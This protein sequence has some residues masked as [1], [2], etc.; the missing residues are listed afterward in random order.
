M[1]PGDLN[2]L[3]NIVVNIK[4][5]EKNRHQYMIKMAKIGTPKHF[6]IG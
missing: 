1:K 2:I 6:K 4:K 5:L 3:L